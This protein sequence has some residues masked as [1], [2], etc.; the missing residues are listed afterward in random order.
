MGGPFP[1]STL[2]P[3]RHVQRTRSSAVVQPPVPSLIMARHLREPKSPALAFRADSPAA[4]VP[5]LIHLPALDLRAIP[6]EYSTPSW[7]RYIRAFPALS[8]L[9]LQL[10]DI[11]SCEPCRVLRRAAEATPV[12]EPEMISRPWPD[13][14]RVRRTGR[15]LRP[16]PGIL[17][18][19]Q[20]GHSGRLM[21]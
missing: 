19:A 16:N 9:A 12:A 21:V 8:R 1:A 13:V 20:V 3:A 6:A 14:D 4:I 18:N 2:P 5:A 15:K 11:P 7:D 10:C 17:K